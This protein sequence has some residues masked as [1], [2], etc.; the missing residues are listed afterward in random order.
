MKCSICQ[1]P[2]SDTET[3]ITFENSS[4]KYLNRKFSNVCYK[5]ACALLEKT[6][7]LDPMNKRLNQPTNYDDVVKREG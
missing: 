6:L 1:Q 5:C 7:E 2:F 4:D 3:C